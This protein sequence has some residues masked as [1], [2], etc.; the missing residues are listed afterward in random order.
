MGVCHGLLSRGADNP[1]IGKSL[2]LIRVPNQRL[3]GTKAAARY[4]GLHEQ[5]L[6][7]LTDLGELPARKM[8]SR[9]VYALEDLDRYIDSLPRWYDGNCEESG[10]ERIINGDQP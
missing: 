6:R 10:T 8:G 2:A 4:L 3:L 7:K 9:R 1:M 5:T